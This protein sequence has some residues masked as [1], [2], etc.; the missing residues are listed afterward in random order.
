[1]AV[2]IVYPSGTW[3][4][5]AREWAR[6]LKAENKSD[7]TIRIYIYALRQLAEWAERQDQDPGTGADPDTETGDVVEPPAEP[8]EVRK[9]HIRA[10][11]AELVGK[12]S[13]ANAHTNYR[14]LRTFFVWLRDEEE[15]I[16]T[17]P[18][19]GVK[20]PIVPEKPIP[21]VPDDELGALL[22]VCEGRDFISRRD[23]AIV[24]LFMDAGNRLAEGIV[25]VDDLD[26]DADVIHVVGKGRKSRTIPFGPKTG[27]AISRYLR[28]RAKH[29]HASRPE[30]WLGLRGPLTADGI[31]Q[32]IERRGKEAGISSLFAH[33]FRHT[34]AHNWQ[35]NGGNPQH[36]KLIM[37]WKSD[38]MLSRYGSSAATERAHNEHRTMR[39]GDR[40]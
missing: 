14:S 30:L 32:M 19:E 31:K 21:I 18:M 35:L 24:R 16:S 8:S 39:M 2:K 29:E 5:V 36:L 3:G 25:M 6:A 1:M 7:N 12:T 10:F 37:G 40:L 26:L 17:S 28:V 9:T 33:R 27:Q 22:K 13:A 15:D 34:L 23:T 11:M 4:L 20:P 38:Q